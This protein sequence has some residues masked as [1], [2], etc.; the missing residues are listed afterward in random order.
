MERGGAWP[1]WPSES[2]LGSTGSGMSSPGP[3]TRRGACRHH[4]LSRGGKRVR[5]EGVAGRGPWSGRDGHMTDLA[6]G[7]SAPVRIAR[8]CR[9]A[10][11]VARPGACRAPPVVTRAG[12]LTLI[13][14]ALTV[15][16]QCRWLE[17]R[18]ARSES[19]ADSAAAAGPRGPALRDP[20]EPLQNGPACRSRPVWR[21]GREYPALRPVRPAPLVSTPTYSYRGA[22]RP[23]VPPPAP[24]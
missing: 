4:A 6:H 18:V 20:R 16:V 10:I 23:S 15:T 5:G 3:A 24:T 13:A 14:G 8:R 9:H 1:G 21:T 12:G 19:G 2:R 22:R 7:R 11:P 17:G